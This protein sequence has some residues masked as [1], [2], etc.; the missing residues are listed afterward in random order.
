MN[1][2]ADRCLALI[3]QNGVNVPH[4]E[5]LEPYRIVYD[6][7]TDHFT[8]ISVFKFRGGSVFSNPMVI[9]CQVLLIYFEQFPL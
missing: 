9:Y 8:V 1:P 3:F 6:N 2:T 4:I 5:E 7:L